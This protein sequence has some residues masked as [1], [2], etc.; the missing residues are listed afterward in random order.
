MNKKP[1]LLLL[2]FLI[3]L[4]PLYKG[5]ET[6]SILFSEGGVDEVTGSIT[7]F[8]LS[9]WVVW[10]F[11]V[12]FAVYFKWSAK[13]NLFFYITYTLLVLDFGMYGVFTQKAVNLYDLPTRFEDNYTLGV[14]TAVQQM[15]IA[16]ILTFFLQFS[17]KIF[18]TKWH[19][20]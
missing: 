15:L 10:L 19:R 17:V 5:F 4:Y 2:L 3:L 6:G 18:E 20:R 1:L 11:I 16:G 14:F 13:Q 9:I 7:A 8:Q 12:S